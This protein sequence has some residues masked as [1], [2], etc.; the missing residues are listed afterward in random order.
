MDIP[1]CGRFA[2]ALDCE[3]EQKRTKELIVT[4][5]FMVGD[6]ECT[7]NVDCVGKRNNGSFVFRHE[8]TSWEESCQSFWSIHQLKAIVIAIQRIS[9]QRIVSAYQAQAKRSNR[10]HPPLT[11]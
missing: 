6:L 2:K 8:R 7:D 5:H 10:F 11:R 9:F 1:W 4:W 3:K